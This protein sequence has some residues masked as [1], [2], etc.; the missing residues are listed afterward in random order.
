MDRDLVRVASQFQKGYKVMYCSIT[1]IQVRPDK[2]DEFV[3]TYAEIAPGATQESNDLKSVQLLT[4]RSTGK[5]LI[6]GWWETEAAARAWETNAWAQGSLG[7]LQPLLTT[8]IQFSRDYYD[9][10]FEH[11]YVAKVPRP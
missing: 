10:S 11:E 2:V 4:E 1:S 9:V 6:I 7:K 3:R 8:P 5:V